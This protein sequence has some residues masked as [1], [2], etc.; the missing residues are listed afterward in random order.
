[1]TDLSKKKILVIDHGLFLSFALRMAR[2]KNHF[3]KVYY[4]NATKSGRPTVS[5]IFVGQGYQE[6]EVL[7]DP[8]D[9]I[10][11]V[12]VLA[13]PDVLDGPKQEYLRRT[14]YNVW[15]SGKGDEL[16]LYRYYWK[17]MI[18][19]VGLAVNPYVIIKGIP[20]LREYL[21]DHKN[22]YIKISLLRGLM[23]TRKHEE[24][25]LTKGFLDQKEVELG[26]EAKHME[27][28]VE[29]PVKTEVEIA[30]DHYFVKDFPDKAINGVEIKD[31]GY[32]GMVQAYREMPKQILKVDEALKPVLKK[33]GY[34]NL[35][36]IELRIALDGTAHP[37]DPCCRQG[38]PSGE[39]Q[40]AVWTNF[41]EIVYHGAHGELVQPEHDNIFVAQA[42]IYHTGIEKGWP[43]VKIPKEVRP[44]T[45]LY[46]GYREGEHDY[47]V[48]QPDAFDE[49]GSVCATGATMQ[50]AIDLCKERAEQ[51]S[52]DVC[53]KCES[54]EKAGEEFDL[55][56]KMKMSVKPISA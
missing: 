18:E 37:I 34:A 20:L 53:V 52:G 40:L 15:G 25:W 6:I 46:Y 42:M 23:E 39:A 12:D 55:M 1:M 3:G 24:Y 30:G 14:G 43:A 35:L 31:E 9:M 2:G 22:K 56:K 54:L 17:R 21:R 4:H 7:K 5:S 13:F 33:Y 27:F 44:Y 28:L 41:P 45:N 48:P 16:E 50:E 49:L 29:D 11:E 26:P 19:S 38:S 47:V 8:W 10:D 32:V 36:A 51:I